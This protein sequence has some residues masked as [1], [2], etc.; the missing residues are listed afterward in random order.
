MAE[1]NWPR[2]GSWSISPSFFISTNGE[3]IWARRCQS[4]GTVE[5][6]MIDTLP[7]PLHPSVCSTTVEKMSGFDSH[8]TFPLL[9]ALVSR[10]VVTTLC[11]SLNS[12]KSL[13]TSR[14]IASRRC[15]AIHRQEVAMHDCQRLV[16]VSQTQKMPVHCTC[17]TRMHL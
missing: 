9:D 5:S 12:T 8:I 11:S 4:W 13:L 2:H 14:A 16:T 15:E 6:Q 10:Y 7:T 1:A 17:R 3:C